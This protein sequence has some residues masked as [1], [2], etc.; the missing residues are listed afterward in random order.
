MQ[1]R[2]IKSSSPRPGF[3]PGYP[4]ETG[5]PDILSRLALLTLSN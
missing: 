2:A 5:L 4:K 1:N 3:E